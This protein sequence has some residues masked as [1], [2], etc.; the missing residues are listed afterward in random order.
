MPRPKNLDSFH[1]LIARI[2]QEAQ[3]EGHFASGPLTPE[4]AK[5]LRFDLY[6]WREGRRKAE[7]GR[8]E[9]GLDLNIEG[10]SIR[11]VPG[12]LVANAK[13]VRLIIDPA[14]QWALGSNF[15]AIAEGLT[16]NGSFDELEAEFLEKEK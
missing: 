11:L 3:T 10:F 13:T 16:K 6:S 15:N 7:E 14:P 8:K 5:A 1:P 2:W 12:P 4:A 9:G